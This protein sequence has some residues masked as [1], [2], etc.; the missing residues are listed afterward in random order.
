MVEQYLRTWMAL[1]V[2]LLALAVLGPVAAGGEI[3]APAPPGLETMRRCMRSEQAVTGSARKIET[4]KH[5][6]TKKECE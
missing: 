2:V 6:M 5:G 4:R 3:A 1:A